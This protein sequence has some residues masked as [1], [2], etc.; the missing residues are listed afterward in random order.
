[1]AGKAGEPGPAS[2]TPQLKAAATTSGNVPHIHFRG[3]EQRGLS[4]AARLRRNRNVQAVRL[5]CRQTN[6]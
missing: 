2:S 3:L 1:M 5:Q 4:S 6:R